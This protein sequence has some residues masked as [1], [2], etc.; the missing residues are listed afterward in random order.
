M[1]DGDHLE[2]WSSLENGITKRAIAREAY[3]TILSRGADVESFV[4]WLMAGTGAT[5]GLLIANIGTVADTLG[6][7]G[8]S[9]VL[10]LLTAALVFGL[11]AK[12][13]AVFIPS[14]ASQ[15]KDGRER[16]NAVFLKHREKRKEIEEVAHRIGRSAPATFTVQ[17]TLDELVKPFPWTGKLVVYFITRKQIAN[18]EENGDLYLALRGWRLQVQMCS[19]QLMAVIAALVSVAIHV[20]N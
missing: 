3:I 1:E 7:G 19:L 13:S 11:F 8:L 2:K 17:D 5:A 15:L 16:L 6:R 14:N 18:Q 10:Y 12:A 20:L 9:W 4:T